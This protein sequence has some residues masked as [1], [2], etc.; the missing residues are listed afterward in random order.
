MTARST[1]SAEAEA[2]SVSAVS[3]VGLMSVNVPAE[4]SLHR[5]SISI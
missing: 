4:P 2:I 3:V 1:S 5:P